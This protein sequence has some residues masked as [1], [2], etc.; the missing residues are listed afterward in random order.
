MVS[1]ILHQGL[2]HRRAQGP[3][4]V[5]Q[6]LH[7]LHHRG[8]D[9]QGMLHQARQLVGRG[10]TFVRAPKVEGPGHPQFGQPRLVACCQRGQVV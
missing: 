4:A 10:G 5:D 2:D 6:G 7:L 3:T 1:W 8:L 9:G